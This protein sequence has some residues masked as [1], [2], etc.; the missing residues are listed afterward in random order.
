MVPHPH[1]IKFKCHNMTFKA[2]NELAPVYPSGLTS[3]SSSILSSDYTETLARACLVLPCRCMCRSSVH[4][5]FPYPSF[6]AILYHQSTLLTSPHLSRLI[7]RPGSPDSPRRWSSPNII[8]P[9]TIIALFI[10]YYNHL[11]TY[12]SSFSTLGFLGNRVCMFDLNFQPS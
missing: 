10:P 4:N 2:W 7:T 8:T 1:G 9:M 5:P 3:H 6:F 11:F 12:L